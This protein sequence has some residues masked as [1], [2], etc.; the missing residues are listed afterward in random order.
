MAAPG[1]V[2]TFALTCGAPVWCTLPRAEG[3]GHSDGNQ[4]RQYSCL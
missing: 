1:T 4:V 2:G 3:D